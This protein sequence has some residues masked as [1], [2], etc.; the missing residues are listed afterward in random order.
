VIDTRG[1]FFFDGLPIFLSLV[2]SFFL[3]RALLVFLRFFGR[4][5]LHNKNK[6]HEAKRKPKTRGTILSA[7]FKKTYTSYKEWE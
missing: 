3:A 5:G 7:S 6:Q 1:E 2:S 4:V